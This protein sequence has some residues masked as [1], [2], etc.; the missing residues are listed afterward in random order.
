[1]KVEVG[2]Y[3]RYKGITDIAKIARIN[4]IIPPDKNIKEAYCQFNNLDGTIESLILKASNNITDLI[5]CLDIVELYIIG[6]E[7]DNITTIKRPETLREL[8]DLKKYIKIG[9]KIK[10]ITTREQFESMSYKVGE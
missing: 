1:M 4:K 2:M 10:S 5:E 3:V 8:K 9:A 6:L 7:E